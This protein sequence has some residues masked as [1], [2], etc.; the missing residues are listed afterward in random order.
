MTFHLVLVA[1]V[2]L[3]SFTLW[4]PPAAGQGAK[5][6]V[7]VRGQSQDVYAYPRTGSQSKGTIL[8]AP[9]DGGWRGF[10]VTMA[11]TM[12]SWGYN[13]YGLDTKRYL[14][15]FAS[16][17]TPPQDSQ[18]MADM[19]TVF[20]AIRKTPS[21]RPVLVGWSEGAGLGALAASSDENKKVFRGVVLIGLPSQAVLRW[22]WVDDVTYVTKKMPD[23]PSVATAPYL[24]KVTPLPLLMI[25]SSG[26]EYTNVPL[27][28][29][30]FDA[31]R[32]PKR[33]SLVEAQNH[34]FEGNE[35]DFF[36]ALQDGLDW[37]NRTTP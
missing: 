15:S 11:E 31:A 25:H 9:G 21:E 3:A 18:V 13:V 37:V 12:A 2:T 6:P 7:S 26:D 29:S 8:F 33:F 24:T 36:R 27:A 4:P 32:E 1:F 28:R 19:R 20:E 17:K 22:R 16:T 30:M 5:V 35:G 23:E 14:E 10:A 34:R